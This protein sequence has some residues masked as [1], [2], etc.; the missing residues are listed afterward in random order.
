[1]MWKR[2]A[3]MHWESDDVQGIVAEVKMEGGAAMW[4][5]LD[6]DTGEILRCGIDRHPLTS[7]NEMTEFLITL[8]SVRDI[9]N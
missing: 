2:K 7:I 3:K 4:T 5:M 9:Y 8:T 1:M 6:T